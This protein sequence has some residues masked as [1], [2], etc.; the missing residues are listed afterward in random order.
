MKLESSRH[1][2]LVVIHCSD[3]YA[4]MDIGV[5]DIRQWHT[6]EPRNWSDIGYHFVIRRDGTIET[7]RDVDKIG[8]HCLGHNT[9]SIGICYVGGK[10]DDGSVED[11]RTNEQK[12]ALAALLINL[13]II[14]PMV[15]V[16]GHNQLTDKKHCPGYNVQEDLKL[17]DVHL[18]T[19]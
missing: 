8:S 3:T 15:E 6:S 13:E 9:N 1:I 14:H 4:R 17:I 16:K 18:F 19:L 7:G 12:R 11:N 2:D 10:A 5:E